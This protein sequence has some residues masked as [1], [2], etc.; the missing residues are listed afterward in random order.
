MKVDS[1][2]KSHHLALDESRIEVPQITL[3]Q[4]RFNNVEVF[5]FITFFSDIQSRIESLTKTWF[6][7]VRN[8]LSTS[9]GER[10]KRSLLDLLVKQRVKR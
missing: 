6:N 3:I 5:K 9:K 7:P 8:V 4:T 2:T 1:F 10:R